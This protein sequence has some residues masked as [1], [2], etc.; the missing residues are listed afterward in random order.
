MIATW[1]R[2]SIIAPHMTAPHPTA[3][4]KPRPQLFR[5]LGRGEPPEQLTT[6]GGSYVRANIYKHDSWAATAR[7]ERI[8][9]GPGCPALVCKFNRQQPI[10]LL[11][12]KWLGRRL[13]RRETA[14]LERMADCPW[15]PNSCGPISVDGVVQTHA[16]G[17]D[18]IPGRPLGR[19]DHV[20]PAFFN[21]FRALLDQLHAAD[22]A[23]VDLNKPENIILGDDGLPYLV[24]FQISYMLPR[25]FPGNNIFSR[26]LLRI[27]QRSDWYHFFKHHI[28]LRPDLLPEH[29][30]DI[31]RLRPWWIRM[32]RLI[33]TP[34]RETR[35][36]LLV[37]AGVRKGTGKR[38]TEYDPEDAVRRQME[39][40]ATDRR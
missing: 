1:T 14:V 5:A 31:N 20:E 23:Y 22:I 17:H 28:R 27:L 7:Y 36:R 21:T 25:R 4:G 34:F 13:A 12:M 26:L 9:D 32:W 38:E 11:P 18:F 33:A 40:S 35:R 10:F 15:I 37:L 3:S 24:D 16:A 39:S 19:R 30:R 6:P 8:G 29:E 2:L